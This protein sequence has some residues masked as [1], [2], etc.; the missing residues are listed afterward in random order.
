MSEENK[1][2]DNDTNDNGNYN[3]KSNYNDKI[4]TFQ[5]IA[6]YLN[7]GIQMAGTIGVCVALG[8][9]IDEKYALSPIFTLIFTFLGIFAA[10]YNFFKA[11][12][13]NSKNKM[14]K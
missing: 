14:K 4:G 1:K 10:F 12:S 13:S 11:V 5:V 7:L 2:N 9:W 8:W 3:D 6:P